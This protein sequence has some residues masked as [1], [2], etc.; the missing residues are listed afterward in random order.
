MNDEV[1]KILDRIMHKVE[2]WRISMIK[3]IHEDHQVTAF[4]IGALT[5]ET[6]RVYAMSGYVHSQTSMRAHVQLR[7]KLFSAEWALRAIQLPV[8]QHTEIKKLRNSWNDKTAELCVKALNKLENYSN[9]RDL[10]ICTK[11][12]GYIVESVDEHTYIFKN[13]PDWIGT[14]DFKSEFIS[15]KISMERN[16]DNP[17][18][19]LKSKSLKATSLYKDFPHDI[20]TKT[21]SSNDFWRFWE[22][23]FK[24]CIEVIKDCL[25]VHNYGSYAAT[26]HTKELTILI[27][28]KKLIDRLIS[29]TDLSITSINTFLKWL[30]FNSQTPK[31]FI[32]FHCPL[33]EI[34]DKFLM[35]LPHSVIMTHI[36]T[37]FFRL[38]AH[39]N[40]TAFSSASSDIEK[41]TLNRL[42]THLQGQGHIIKTNVKL[43]ASIAKAEFDFVEYNESES[44]LCIGQ[45]KLT[46]RADSV[47]E[48]DH[49][50]KVLKE[51]ID[52]LAQN[53]VLCDNTSNLKMLF[54]KMGITPTKNV[55]IEYFLLPT[56]FTGSDFL[57]I[58][59]W[60]KVMPV[61]FCLLPRF[62]EC[63]I[64]SVWDE[65]KKLW[66]SLDE[67][68]SSSHSSQVK[69]EIAGLTIFY[70]GLKI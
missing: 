6:F 20:V 68:V 62:K 69:F 44:T 47:A 31:K 22:C 59:D 27:T 37:A 19:F 41:R 28:K 14:N 24:F 70:P 23:L 4:H 65:Y 15:D 36:P 53:K 43:E 57:Q 3:S 50:N 38:F 12:D 40:K 51:G 42:K 58:P 7:E 13:T 1:T 21:Y 66:D 67:K 35:I 17:L 26:S 11:R 49:T 30:T 56:N 61:E 10:V 46:I 60:I 8:F 33:I 18:E 9:I 29:E 55:V 48:V 32:L 63:S 34:N 52:Q 39:H 54:M 2:S 5:E 25:K 45:A 64:G 16:K